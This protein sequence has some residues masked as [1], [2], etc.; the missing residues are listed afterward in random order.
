MLTSWAFSSSFE[1]PLASFSRASIS[2][3]SSCASRSSSFSRLRREKGL[4]QHTV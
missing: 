3:S 1:T 4:H 2:F